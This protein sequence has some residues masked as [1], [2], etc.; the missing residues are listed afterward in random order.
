MDCTNVLV[1]IDRL[2]KRKRVIPYEDIGAEITVMLFLNEI[3]KHHGLLE[4]IISDR[5]T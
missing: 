2:S 4:T 1:V 3:F 5:G